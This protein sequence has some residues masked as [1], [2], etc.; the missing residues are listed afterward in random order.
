MISRTSIATPFLLASCLP[1]LQGCNRYVSQGEYLDTAYTDAGYSS[2][3]IYGYVPPEDDRA[4]DLTPDD[5]GYQSPPR[6]VVIRNRDEA[7]R[8]MDRGGYQPR[9]V[10][11]TN[12]SFASNI[13]RELDDLDRELARLEARAEQKGAAAEA[14]VEPAARDLRM[15][16]SQIE[17]RLFEIDPRDDWD[18]AADTRAEV[19]DLLRDAKQSLA[20]ATDEV[21]SI[22]SND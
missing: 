15:Y 2:P 16:R 6:V 12:Q 18:S 14:A 7:A 5:V 22:R 10:A 20:D 11:E 19:A 1:L 9:P 3:E 8:D 21:N 17:D 13:N 4:V